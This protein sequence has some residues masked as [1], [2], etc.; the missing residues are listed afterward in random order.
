MTFCNNI[1]YFL[2]T[3]R[4][5]T[6]YRVFKSSIVGGY[7]GN[8]DKAT[9][10]IHPLR[11]QTR[12]RCQEKSNIKYYSLVFRCS[13]VWELVDHKQKLEA[14]KKARKSVTRHFRSPEQGCLE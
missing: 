9:L 2:C 8:S 7:L 6:G 4:Y 14:K 13:P 3:Y 10:M 12:L 1:G 11:A 5:C